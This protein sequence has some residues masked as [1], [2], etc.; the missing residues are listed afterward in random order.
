M[1]TAMTTLGH[2]NQALNCIVISD[3]ETLPY[4][5]ENTFLIPCWLRENWT[6]TVFQIELYRLHRALKYSE[7]SSLLQV[8]CQRLGDAPMAPELNK[9]LN[10]LSRSE[11]AEISELSRKKSSHTSLSQL[12]TLQSYSM[13]FCTRSR[14]R[15]LK[16]L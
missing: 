1:L 3:A 9:K 14:T 2:L 16:S 12:R 8:M 7:S 13:S 6:T 5:I 4:R 10:S 15:P 11:Y